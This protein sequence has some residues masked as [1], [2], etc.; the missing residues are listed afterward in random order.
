MQ[1]LRDEDAATSDEDDGEVSPDAL[2][3]NTSPLEEGAAPRVAFLDA[4]RGAAF[5][6]V[7]R[8]DS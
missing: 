4:R 7:S 6:F 5:R 8:I 3:K 1:P 2:R